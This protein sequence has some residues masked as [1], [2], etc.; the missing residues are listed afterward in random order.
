MKRRT[1]LRTTAGLGMA[2][3]GGLA[4]PAVAQGIRELTLITTW[5]EGSPGLG[6]S[7]ERL[8]RRVNEGSDGRL[9][10]KVLPAGKLVSP[11]KTFETVSEGNADMYHAFEYYWQDR[12]KAFAFFAAVPFGLTA[13]EMSSWVKYGGGQELWDETAA[14]FNLKPFLAGN[15]GMQ[16]AGWFRR[17]VRHTK[18]LKG[19][20]MRIAGLGGEVIRRLG[21]KP[22]H[23]S[24]GKI[25]SA[26]E[27]AQIDAAE[28]LAPWNDLDLKL[29]KATKYY[30]YPGFHEPG[31]TIGVA[32]NLKVWEGLSTSEKALLEGAT[33]AEND[34]VLAEFNARNAAALET[35]VKKHGVL[36]KRFPNPVV[37]A[38]GKAA[39]QVM[40]DV[41]KADAQ[42]RKVYESFLAFRRRSLA[43]AKV[44]DQAFSEA[45]LLPFKYG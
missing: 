44:T 29:Y 40:A 17:Q 38:M 24:V 19:L 15:T 9:R 16:M 22:V 2:A 41:A 13:A 10:I 42:T 20:R 32:V 30:Y 3:G 36:L 37:N 7:A 34:A 26:L 1:F 39:G 11:M 14:A 33:A 18:D 21:G 25:L 27:S 6:T 31:T 4:A 45:R 8:A 23:V 35:L 28:W 43:W 12:S 5:P